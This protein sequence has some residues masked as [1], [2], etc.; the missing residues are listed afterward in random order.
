MKIKV[1]DRVR[2]IVCPLIYKLCAP[3]I[4]KQG[5]VVYIYPVLPG[6]APDGLIR[7]RLDGKGDLALYEDE[8]EIVSTK[9]ILCLRK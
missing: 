6:F 3:L 4:G 9:E 1:G 7:V 8:V 2:I 5:R